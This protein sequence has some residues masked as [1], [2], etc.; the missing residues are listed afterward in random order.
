MAAVFGTSVNATPATA[1]SLTSPSITT[2]TTNPA[3]FVHVGI[4]DTTGTTTVNS[5]TITGFGGTATQVK[6]L[7]GQVLTNAQWAIVSVWKIVAPTANTA[8]T[9]QANF[10]ASVAAQLVVETFSGADQTDPSPVGD[11]VS[12]NVAA[13]STTLTPTNLVTGDAST[14]AEGNAAAQ[15]CVA[16]TP[17]GR[18]LNNTTS[19]NMGVGDATNTTGVTFACDAGL[20]L[21][22]VAVRVKQFTAQVTTPIDQEPGLSS[23]TRN[24][25]MLAY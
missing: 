25:T 21:C 6:V 15:N 19:I 5:L 8:G 22:K 1:T 14:G 10:S 7:A 17:N 24:V 12:S 3:V 9:V 4:F 20:N 2:P 23:M 16:V 13:A 11:A 18:F